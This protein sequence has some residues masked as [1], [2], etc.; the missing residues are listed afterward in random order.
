MVVSNDIRNKALDE[1]LRPYLESVFIYPY[2]L[3]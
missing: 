1:N 3:K 2:K